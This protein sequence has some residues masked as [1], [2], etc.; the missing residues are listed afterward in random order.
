MLRCLLW[1]IAAAIRPRVLLVADNLLEAQGP[2]R[3]L[4]VSVAL[5]SPTTTN[6]AQ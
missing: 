2:L 1:V 6:G 3:H 5:P 4:E